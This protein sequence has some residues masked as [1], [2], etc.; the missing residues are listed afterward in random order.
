MRASA[1]AL[2]AAFALALAACG[3]GNERAVRIG[4][5]ADCT[6][7]LGTFHELELSAAELPLLERGGRLV[8]GGVG[9]GVSG[10]TVAGTSVDLITGCAESTTYSVL[11][12]EARRL[13]EKERVDVLIGPPLDSDGLVLR[14]IARRSPRVTFLLTLSRAQS[15]T[16]RD[17]APNVFRFQPD[18]AQQT[19]GLGAYA[20]EKLGWRT[21]AVVGEDFVTSWERAAGF[22]AEFCA[23]GGRITKRLFV[24]VGAASPKLTEAL[25]P[26]VDGVALLPAVAFVD[27][28]PFVRAYAQRRPQIA[29]HLVL[30]PEMLIVGRNRA[31]LAKAASGAV[32]G[33]SEPYVA[34]N[35]VWVRIRREF[36]RWFPGV[37]PAKG[38][39]AEYPLPL[40]YRNAVEA[41]LV[42]LAR[43]D[44][45][46]SR[47]Q[48]RFR[49]ALA[50]L[51]LE[52]PTGT[53]RLDRNRQAIASAYLTRVSASR[54]PLLRT[55]GVFPN[56]EQTFDGY[57]SA[58]T[59]PPSAVAPA[60][61]RRP[62]PP[63]ARPR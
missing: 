13:I 58:T 55:I 27:W 12:A 60:C 48:A 7:G 47:E 32:A 4:V 44:G 8:R 16:L 45:D 3:G 51:A 53:I 14:E 25:P 33:G 21:A 20:Y 15:T 54:R 62:P 43:A 34:E 24:P 10:A 29:R 56:V 23:L 17:A 50:H 46:L 18:G 57:F 59:Q 36:Q 31:H 2:A 63:W 42:A 1:A 28:S 49:A 30:G 22:V 61:R 6:G 52:A 11:I 35:P 40:A 37:I 38:V 39:P 26:E 19:A 5:L 41:A 9:G